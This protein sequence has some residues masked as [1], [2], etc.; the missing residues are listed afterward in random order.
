MAT[1]TSRELEEMRAAVG[2]LMPDTCRILSKTSI[3]DGAGSST[4]TWGTI[5]RN[6]S[7]RMDKASGSE[8]YI[9]GGRQPFAGYILTVPYDTTLLTTHRVEHG[10]YTYAVIAVNEDQSNL[11]VTRAEVERVS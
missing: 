7:C 6:V 5:T 9:A 4:D 1:L 8:G 11:I 3:S 2:D 10:G